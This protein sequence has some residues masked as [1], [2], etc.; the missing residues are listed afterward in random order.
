MARVSLLP[1][2]HYWFGL[3]VSILAGDPTFGA[4]SSHVPGR[5]ASHPANLNPAHSNCTS[6]T[7][8]ASPG[9]SVSSSGYLEANGSTTFYA[10]PTGEN[11]G[12]N[13]Y[14]MT[15]Q[16]QSCKTIMIM[17]NGGNCVQTT[18]TT[19]MMKTT[20]MT[21]TTTMPPT[22]T[23]KPT[24]T[25]QPTC[26]TTTET[27]TIT[28][29]TTMW[30]TMTCTASTVTEMGSTVTVTKG[31]ATVT[32]TCTETQ[33]ETYTVTA[34]C[35]TSS[36]APPP[37]TTTSMAPPPTTSA[38]TTMTTSSPPTTTAPPATTTAA[39]KTCDTS[40]T[41]AYQ[42]PHLIVP[43]NSASPDTEYGT[44]YNG[45]VSSTISS[46]FD[47]DIPSSYEGDTCTIIF[48]F[49]TQAELTT[50]SFTT[51]GSG[52]IDFYS[53]SS[54]A[55][56]STTYDTCPATSGMLAS[57]SA[58]PGNSYVVSSGP[59]A[60]GQRIGVLAKATGSYALKFFEDYNPSPIGVFLT[61]C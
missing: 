19:T 39:G 4:R 1:T 34:A 26:P 31:G 7:F 14:T 51:S 61:A 8:T 13:I 37:P 59:C 11:G 48:L 25:A 3:P 30:Q 22:T 27:C 43:I 33:T 57:I 21:P 55:T 23:M 16:G 49:P 40:L 41:G 36:M 38:M 24:T 29:S 9:F 35:M 6:L 54:P 60:A 20:T 56:L 58:M 53:L 52:T 15:L 42:T 44:S 2:Q 47:F 10:C 18:T 12:Y 5:R 28:E 46:I 17:V 32:E 50:S 45:E